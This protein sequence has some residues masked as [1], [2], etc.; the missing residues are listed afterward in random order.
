MGK[1]KSDTVWSWMF[2][3]AIV[4]FFLLVLF[5]GQ[6]KRRLKPVSPEIQE[7]WEREDSKPYWTP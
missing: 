6:N 1:G 5:G 3:A 2:I 4:L 7:Q